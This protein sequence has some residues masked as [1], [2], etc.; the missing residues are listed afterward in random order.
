MPTAGFGQVFG[1]RRCRA[2][3]TLMRPA[4]ETGSTR[5]RQGAKAV[6]VERLPPAY[7]IALHRDLACTAWYCPASGALLALDFHRRDEKPSDDL[8]L[9][10][11]SVERIM[12]EAR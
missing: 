8:D 12:R 3:H 5:W 4:S 6:T 10:L 7:R 11:A 1:R 9:D 2:S